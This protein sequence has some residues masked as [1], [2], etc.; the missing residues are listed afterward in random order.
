MTDTK[1]GLNPGEVEVNP[2]Q[3]PEI[4]YKNLDKQ[5]LVVTELARRALV[6]KD[7]V[8]L[9]IAH[10]FI[11]KPV[12]QNVAPAFITQLAEQF[13]KVQGRLKR[14]PQL[15]TFLNTPAVDET[16]IGSDFE[17]AEMS[18]VLGKNWLNELHAAESLELGGMFGLLSKFG[19]AR[20][21]PEKGPKLKQL[22][23]AQERYKLARDV[24]LFA[25]GAELASIAEPHVDAA[26]R[27][28]LPSGTEL[29]LDEQ[30]RELE[31]DFLHPEQW[32]S[33]RQIKDRV[34]EVEINGKNICLKSK[35]RLD[36]QIC[37][38]H[39]NHHC[40]LKKNLR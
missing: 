35:K 39:T 37:L 33:R 11:D 24:K 27:L 21:D 2:A 12:D 26:G 25:L 8:F 19:Q 5:W 40:L 6:N 7:P 36:I 3:F 13:P 10:S 14:Y 31:P 38:N 22:K 32:E 16:F 9:E 17:S 30:F 28:E 15:Q 18:I 1:E 34:Y 20:K 23:L 29:F 4:N